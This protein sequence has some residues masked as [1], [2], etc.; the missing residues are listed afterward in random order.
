MKLDIQDI[1]SEIREMYDIDKV[2]AIYAIYNDLIDM[3]DDAVKLICKLLSHFSKSDKEYLEKIK[4]HI[5]KVGSF[6]WNDVN[7]PI[8]CA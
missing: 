5:E 3:N 7:H 2:D 4:L 6:D 1:V 8:N